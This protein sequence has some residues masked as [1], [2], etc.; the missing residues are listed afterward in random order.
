MTRAKPVVG[1]EGIKV[2]GN[3]DYCYSEP[4]SEETTHHAC[5]TPTLQSDSTKSPQTPPKPSTTMHLPLS[6]LALATLA[7]TSASPSGLHQRDLPSCEEGTDKGQSVDGK[8]YSEC[9]SQVFSKISFPSLSFPFPKRNIRVLTVIPF[10]LGIANC[11]KNCILT[12]T[13]D[14]DNSGNACAGY[15]IQAGAAG[16]TTRTCTGVRYFD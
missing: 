11:F 15:C 2:E 9:I 12:E 5:Q 10:P 4:L 1:P 7:L 16:S 3:R 13:A 6:L 14:N 8:E